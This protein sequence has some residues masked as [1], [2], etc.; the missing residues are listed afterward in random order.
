MFG[1]S[2]RSRAIAKEPSAPR[3]PRARPKRV[4]TQALREAPLVKRELVRGEPIVQR[5]LA[6]TIEELSCVGYRALR[7]EDVAGRA[8][9]NKTTVYRRWPE[10][11]ALVKDALRCM[12]S[13]KFVPPETGA[14]RSDLVSLGRQLVNA[15]STPRGRSLVRMM[16]A[17]STDDELSGIKRDFRKERSAVPLAVL[18]GAI[19]RGELSP[20]ADLHLMIQTFVGAI[21]HRVFFMSETVTDAYLGRLAD[22]LVLGVNCGTQ[23]RP[24]GARAGRRFA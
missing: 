9:V 4:A 22:L 1:M 12:T 3:A 10:K 23:V 17:E 19:S 13:T 2:E 7:I 18:A 5:V 8:A 20:D 24:A 15:F 14:L 21:Q 16:V 6:A 11:C